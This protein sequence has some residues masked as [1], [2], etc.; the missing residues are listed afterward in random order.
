[1]VELEAIFISY[2]TILASHEGENARRRQRG[3]QFL[4]PG[5][6][7]GYQTAFRQWFDAIQAPQVSAEIPAN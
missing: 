6:G 1:M 3:R 4:G 7:G 2:E 5:S